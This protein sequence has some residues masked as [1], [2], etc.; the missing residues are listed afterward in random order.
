M[1]QFMLPPQ[2]VKRLQQIVLET[3]GRIGCSSSWLQGLLK[4]PEKAV[5]RSTGERVILN[6]L[7]HP[8]DDTVNTVASTA[9]LQFSKELITDQKDATYTA[10]CNLFN[11]LCD[12]VVKH[13]TDWENQPIED[14]N[15]LNDA[16][17]F[18]MALHY[19]TFEKDNALGLL[20]E[21]N[22]I[23]KDIILEESKT[24]QKEKTNVTELFKDKYIFS[25]VD[26]D[27]DE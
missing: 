11:E 22:E 21:N 3:A 8:V 25:W 13:F 9:N 12:V 15:A 4:N 27:D 1:F 2:I 19:S 6:A 20:Q 26:D 10:A 7:D 17:N 5:R 18:F 23:L 16:L 24:N 14:F